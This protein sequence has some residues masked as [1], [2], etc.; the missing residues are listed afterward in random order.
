MIALVSYHRK[1]VQKAY[2]NLLGCSQLKIAEFCFLRSN[3]SYL[4]NLGYMRDIFI[5]L[6]ECSLQ[7]TYNLTKEGIYAKDMARYVLLP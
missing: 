1:L 7:K 3:V 4:Q 2:C 6:Y 5:G